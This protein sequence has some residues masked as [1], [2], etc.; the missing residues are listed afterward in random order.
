MRRIALLGLALL[1]FTGC[2]MPV[3]N[4]FRD[5]VF[6]SDTASKVVFA[7]VLLPMWVMLP[8]V[9]AFFVNPVRGAANVPEAVSE[10]WQ[11]KNDV[12]WLGYGVLG[13]V[14]VIGTPLAAI[15]Y[16]MFSEQFMFKEPID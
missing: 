11:W 9:D 4:Y 15:S 16:T 13:P 2:Q 8:F 1:L 12:P 3:S 6:P 14:K 5:H 7:P 10:L